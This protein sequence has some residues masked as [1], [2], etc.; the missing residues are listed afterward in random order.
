MAPRSC[1]GLLSLADSISLPSLHS[2][3]TKTALSHFAAAVEEDA[4][5]FAALNLA[6]LLFLVSHDNL[7][8]SHQD[9]LRS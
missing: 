2:L 9:P 7:K 4:S 6:Q 5:G 1:F 8:V 3:C